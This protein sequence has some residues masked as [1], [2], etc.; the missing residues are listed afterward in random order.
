MTIK[1]KADVMWASLNQVNEMSG[2]YQVD[3]CNLSKD[4]VKELT[5]AGITV[6][7]KPGDEQERGDFITCKSTYPIAAVD[8]KNIIIDPGIKIANGSEVVA[9][10]NPFPWEFKG[11]K[12]VSASITK[13][14]IT[15]LIEYVSESDE[16]FSYEDAV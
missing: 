13:L 7:N 1:V 14:I 5:A 4:A 11:K 16:D 10:I 12:G 3:L 6:K 8:A 9:I 15:N 2:K